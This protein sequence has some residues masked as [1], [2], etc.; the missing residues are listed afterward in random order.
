MSIQ[1]RRHWK[2][3][4]KLQMIEEARKTDNTVSGACPRVCGGM[5]A[6]RNRD[7]SVL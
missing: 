7:R 1:K 4:E 2:A 3:E 6:I 5:P